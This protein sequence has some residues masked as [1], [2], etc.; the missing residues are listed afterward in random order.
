MKTFFAVL[1]TLVSTSAFADNSSAAVDAGSEMPQASGTSEVVGY[2]TVLDQGPR[3]F[4]VEVGVQSIGDYCNQSEHNFS[5]GSNRSVGK[6]QATDGMLSL[7]IRKAF[8]TNFDLSLSG[9]ILSSSPYSSDPADEGMT[10]T[11]VTIHPISMGARYHQS[12]FADS[13]TPFVQVDL[14]EALINE[15]DYV[16]SE[17]SSSDY[18][19]DSQ[20]R[21]YFR[22][23][24]K[25]AVG[26]DFFVTP[27]TPF[28]V[29]VRVGYLV[30][31]EFGGFTTGVDLG[32]AF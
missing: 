28:Y 2:D 1:L 17:T 11:R 25:I 12:Y 16:T 4:A 31:S 20:D 18:S 26:S 7:T 32:Y 19:A 30:M 13:I 5:S 22:P 29:G 9:T 8:S 3:P 14:G 21:N 10:Y 23:F 27:K 6:Y 24:A 15:S